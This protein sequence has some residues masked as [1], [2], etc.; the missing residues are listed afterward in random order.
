MKYSG[1]PPWF[2]CGLA[3]ALGSRALL[4]IPPGNPY[5]VISERNVF[6]LRP[7]PRRL[8]PP[9]APLPKVVPDGITDILGVKQALLRVCSPAGPHEPAKEVP[10]VLSV[11]QREGPI[12][13][14]AIDEA[15]RNIEINNSGTIMMLNLDRDG[16]K[17][18]PTSAKPP[19]PAK[20]LAPR[21]PWIR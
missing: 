20:A 21:L 19:A 6:G 12:E 7:P 15:T 10:C 4:A 3:F 5:R 1:T 9:P 2:L 18:P 13:V 16:P 17:E 11:G 14:L 8:D